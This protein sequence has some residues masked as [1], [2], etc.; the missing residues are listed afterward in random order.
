M[1]RANEGVNV[2]RYRHVLGAPHVTPLVVAVV[3]A[4]VPIGMGTLAV[5]VFVQRQT[6]SYA[7]AGQVAAAL[8]VGAAA[9]TPL[10]GRLIDRVGQAAVLLP[11][12][13]VSPLALLGVVAVGRESAPLGALAAMAFVA[14]SSSPPVLACLRS[15]W[16]LLL[17]ASEQLIRTGLAVDALLLEAAFIAGPLLAGGLIAA[18]SPESALVVAAGGTLT[19]TLGFVAASPIRRSRGIMRSDLRL[20][21]PLRTRGLQTILFATFPIGVLFG[22]F[23]VMAPAMGEELGGRQSVGGVLVAL[24]AV[25]SALG[26]LWWGMR[27]LATPVVGYVRA[28]WLMPFGLALVALPNGLLALAL[29]SLLFGVPFAPF[30]AAGGELAHR[31]APAGMGTE[32]FT[33]I[34]TALIAGAASGQAMAGPIIEHAGWR[35]AALACAAVGTL[36]AALLVARRPTLAAPAN[37]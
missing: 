26:G 2:R 31:L 20:L 27:P 9:G 29:L 5:V 35:A 8:A 32:S 36:G 17:R 23:D 28:A 37:R 7:A 1:A 30:S 10:L 25:G 11:C 21:G 4:V 24:T 19:G 13:V 6:G 15:M 33:W 16:P 3:V 34:T 12:A 14:G 18:V 22:A